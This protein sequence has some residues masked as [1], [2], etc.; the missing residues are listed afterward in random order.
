MRLLQRLIIIASLG[1]IAVSATAA[2][3]APVEGVEYQRLQ[4]AQP[5]DTGKKVEVLEFFWYN[6][7]HCHV[8]EPFLAEWTKRQGDR[9]VVKRVP[10]GFRES[11]VPQQKLYYTL[12]AMNRLD[13]HKAVFD[14]I[15][16]KRQKLDREDQIMA[17]IDK[18]DID[19]KKFVDTY[20]SFTV[21]S[22]V[23]RVRQLQE[24]YRIEGVPTVAID[25]QYVT[26]PSIIGQS[27]RGVSEDVLNN[28]TLQV[29]DALVAK[30]AK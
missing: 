11:F 20:N 18:Q 6:C 7:P 8:F 1:F 30:K 23:N 16:G 27:M 26:S 10:V 9:V 5:T 24:T 14:T 15:H 25:G 21:Q 22:K 3:N 17:F 2:P 13:L 29:M 19:K 28:A 4:Q 12:E